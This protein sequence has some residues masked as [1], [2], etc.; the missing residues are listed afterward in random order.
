MAKQKD[1]NAFLTINDLAE[2]TEE[3]LLPAI[4]D[5][6]KDTVKN[7]TDKIIDFKLGKHNIK[8]RDY[9]D[10]KLAE[11]K[12]DIISY[13]KGDQER[14]KNWKLKVV[15][16]LDRKKLAKPDEIKFLKDLVR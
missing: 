3:V 7:E 5:I 2:F 13:M 11:T 8:L 9:I 16:I 12:G 10:T 1:K 14:D 6:V 15:K 4:K